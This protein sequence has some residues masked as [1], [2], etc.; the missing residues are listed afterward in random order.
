MFNLAFGK[1]Y[2]NYG[3]ASAIGMFLFVILVGAKLI[4]DKCF[5]EENVEF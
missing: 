5:P 4:I 2:H 1:E 3:Y